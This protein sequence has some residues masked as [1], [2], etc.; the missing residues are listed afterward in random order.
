[1]TEKYLL[2]YRKSETPDWQSFP[3][4]EVITV[5]SAPQNQLALAEGELSQAHFELRENPTGI[6]LKDVDAELGETLLFGEP[7]PAHRPT[8]L[9]LNQSFFAG[10]Y[11]FKVELNSEP[12]EGISFVRQMIQSIKEFGIWKTVGIGIFVILFAFIA[13][14]LVYRNFI[15]N[16]DSPAELIATEA[17]GD[18][19]EVAG[20]LVPTELFELSSTAVVDAVDA[21]ITAP[22]MGAFELE[23][24]LLNAGDLDI[25]D[26][27]QFSTNPGELVS[28]STT[29][30][31]EN[32]GFV[33]A[34]S[35][36]HKDGRVIAT[37]ME[38]IEAP[39]DEVVDGVQIPKWD[40]AEIAI[41]FLWDPVIHY[42]ED[43]DR[44]VIA[45]LQPTVYGAAD[46]EQIYWVEGL[47]QQENSDTEFTALARFGEEGTLYD[48]LT[49]GV[50]GSERQTP[51]KVNYRAGD[52]FTPYE[53]EF[54]HDP[55][56][57]EEMALDLAGGA[58]PA[59]W[60][61][62]LQMA[63][64]NTSDG[65][66]QF[67]I[68]DFQRHPGTTLTIG[69]EG[70]WWSTETSPE[71]DFVAG[72]VVEDLDSNLWMGYIPIIVKP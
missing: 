53:Q 33:Y 1:M 69:E 3:F 61:S 38:F 65:S 22:G 54:I 9:L 37:G 47:Y 28:M 66:F 14:M 48:I 64:G 60:S 49:F 40:K 13:A 24:M 44:K 23:E 46:G 52:T 21:I 70:L 59:G 19:I 45:L 20:T 15:K 58:L 68:G 67:G 8:A 2:Y 35:G 18:V 17:I 34:Y 11:E 16:P 51:Y 31:G 30:V 71:G 12:E 5:G 29:I 62:L 57:T 39:S 10:G 6:Y 50:V 7:L 56:S 41:E 27:M 25:S 55:E 4:S 36:I 72:I 32:V 43:G 26:L 63:I 42:L